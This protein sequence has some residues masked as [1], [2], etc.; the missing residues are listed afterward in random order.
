[1]PRF[2]EIRV[3]RK[4]PAAFNLVKTAAIEEGVRNQRSLASKG[5]KRFQD[6]RRVDRE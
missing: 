2:G 1:M 6:S 5:F 3:D 4:M